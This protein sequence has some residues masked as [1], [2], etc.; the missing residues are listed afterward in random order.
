MG[1]NKKRKKENLYNIYGIV[2]VLA[3]VGMFFVKNYHV[4]ILLITIILIAVFFIKPII[5]F[6]EDIKNENF[7]IAKIIEDVCKV[8]VAIYSVIVCYFM[9]VA[10]IIKYENNINFIQNF[11]YMF[12]MILI[13]DFTKDI[14][15]SIR[16]ILD[17]VNRKVLKQESKKM[18]SKSLS[19][20]L[21]IYSSR[22]VL[23]DLAYGNNGISNINDIMSIEEISIRVEENNR[24]NRTLT[25]DNL[26]SFEKT[27]EY[28]L[29]SS[30]DKQHL[31]I[32]NFQDA[33]RNM[34]LRGTNT[35][36]IFRYEIDKEKYIELYI[37]NDYGNIKSEKYK[38]YELEILTNGQIFVTVFCNDETEYLKHFKLVH[39]NN[40][41]IILNSNELEKLKNNKEVELITVLE[42]LIEQCDD[43]SKIKERSSIFIFVRN[44]FKEVKKN[45]N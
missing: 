9:L 13:M 32:E 22:V 39:K 3:L 11:F 10:D 27:R 8:M 42:E 35:S 19:F 14:F 16:R 25:I 21:L 41:P 4:M 34:R 44:N 24:N 45:I 33:M 37:S 23:F 20:I 18:I 12:I 6:H 38:L 31:I 1:D 40:E 43:L 30:N 2:I 15:I 29:S 26:I 5:E 7:T 17:K 36:E 28:T